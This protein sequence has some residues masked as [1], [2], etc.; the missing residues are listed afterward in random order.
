[1][2]GMWTLAPSSLAISASF[3]RHVRTAGLVADRRAVRAGLHPVLGHHV[4]DPDVRLDRD[5]LDR[6]QAEVILRAIPV[7]GAIARLRLVPPL[8]D[9]ED[10]ALAPASEI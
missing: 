4:G 1:M 5:E 3:P 6:T 10:E 8:R 2:R 7:P 9:G